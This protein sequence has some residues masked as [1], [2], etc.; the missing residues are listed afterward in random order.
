[1]FCLFQLSEWEGRNGNR[2]W[3][4][5]A[6]PCLL[7]VAVSVGLN[8]VERTGTVFGLT[9]M[10]LSKAIFFIIV[11]AGRLYLFPQYRV[12]CGTELLFALSALIL[13]GAGIPRVW[14]AFSWYYLLLV[15]A[16]TAV[17]GFYLTLLLEVLYVLG[18]HWS[19]VRPENAGELNIL[20]LWRCFW[21]DLLYLGIWITL[22]LG[23]AFYYLVNFYIMDVI[24]Y[25]QLLAGI[26][27][28]CGLFFFAVARSR[29]KGW[30]REELGMLDLKIGVY[31][32]WRNVDARIADADLPVY[33]YLV[34][35]R[36][37][38]ERLD[39]NLVFPGTVAFYLFCVLFLLSL[40]LWV[41]IVIKV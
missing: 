31:L 37:Y 17:W 20:G 7:W 18:V 14:N 29:I 32:D 33:R 34:L 30:F 8:A 3:L 27:A 15:I 6:V 11:V 13:C 23:L 22:L 38:L 1:V 39:K 4:G 5:Y 19:G 28:G 41:G 40:P 2:V 9:A 36:E 16:D 21:T 24:F 35:T 10:L 25:S 26:L 12:E